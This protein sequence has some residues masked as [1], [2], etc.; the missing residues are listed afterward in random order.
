M[1]YAVEFTTDPASFL[2]VAGDLLAADPVVSTVM[3]TVT[4]RMVGEPAP[5]DRPQWWAV[6][7]DQDGGLAGFAMRTARTPP[8]PLFVL[9]MADQAALA[10][11]RAVHDRGETVGGL[12]GS[13]PAAEI[14]AA[15]LARLQGDAVEVAQ[16]TRLFELGEL[17]TP[18]GVPGSLRVATLDDFDL[19]KQW[20]DRFMHDA[21]EQAGRDPDAA[22]R[23]EIEPEDLRKRVE[24]GTYWFWLDEAGER[25]H[26]TGANPPA[27]GVAR[28]GP[29]YTP[30]EQR[31]KGYAGAAV[32][33]VSQIFIDQGARVCLYTDQANPTSNGVYQALGYV[34]VVDQVNLRIGDGS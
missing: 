7:R 15:E 31:R 34:A 26:L 19:A 24:R 30:P 27:Y 9:P 13:L 11:A 12:N 21:D 25:V 1:T 6:I 16:H 8:H 22:G 33:Q 18:H 2:A 29:V 14:C 23:E 4:S 3:A 10:L 5:V 32:A 28:I 17:R 20:V